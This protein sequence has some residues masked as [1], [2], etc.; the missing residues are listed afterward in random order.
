MLQNAVLQIRVQLF[1]VRRVLLPS[2]WKARIC[3]GGICAFP[4]GIE[5]EKDVPSPSRQS[6]RISPP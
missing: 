3:S 2:G 5:I 1:Q 4:K 6:A